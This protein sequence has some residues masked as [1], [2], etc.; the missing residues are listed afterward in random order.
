[1]DRSRTVLLL[2]ELKEKGAPQAVLAHFGSEA[3]EYC[4]VA[5]YVRELLIS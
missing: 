1:M 4:M 2:G 3:Y 5:P